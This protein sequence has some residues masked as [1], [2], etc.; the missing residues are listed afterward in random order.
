MD[1]FTDAYLRWVTAEAG[2]GSPEFLRWVDRR[3]HR[4]V[5]D[6]ATRRV[7]AW[8]I[9]GTPSV[10]IPGRWAYTPASLRPGTPRL[11]IAVDITDPEALARAIKENGRLPYRDPAVAAP[12][13][14]R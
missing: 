6:A 14:R 12:V 5:V 1:R 13:V 10:W 4:S 9:S 3:E 8:R 7:R 11:Q 2:A